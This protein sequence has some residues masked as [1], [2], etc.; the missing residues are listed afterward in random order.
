MRNPR[1]IRFRQRPRPMTRQ[2]MTAGPERPELGV[3]EEGRRCGAAEEA[4]DDGGAGVGPAANPPRVLLPVGWVAMAFGCPYLRA[5]TLA[6][7]TCT[8]AEGDT[9]IRQR[10]CHHNIKSLPSI[11]IGRFGCAGALSLWRHSI[12]LHGGDKTTRH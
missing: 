5:T 7:P 4:K 1:F 6:R 10:P 2:A 8:S 3:V 11:I 9:R 12:Q